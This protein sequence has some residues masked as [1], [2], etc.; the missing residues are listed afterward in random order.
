[1]PG[2]LEIQQFP[3]W[4]KLKD[5]RVPLAFDL[6]VTARCNNDCRHC[7]I[8]LPANDPIA[9]ARELLPA[10]IS[11]IADEAVSL[12]AIWCL[13]TGGEPLLRALV[14]TETSKPC[15][16]PTKNLFKGG[17]ACQNLRKKCFFGETKLSNLST[18]QFG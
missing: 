2:T 5:K 12:G 16:R 10:E 1:M 14:N 9:R 13:I 17:V 15:R 6:E 3:L 18:R 11:R 8:N 4:D 7:Y